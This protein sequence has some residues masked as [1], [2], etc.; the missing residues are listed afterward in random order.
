MPESPQWV[1]LAYRIPREP[2]TPRIAIWRK[3]RKLG[4]VQLLDGLVALP[5]DPRT[6]E[7][8]EWIA[9]D[10][11][12][13][14]G[15]AGIWLAQPSTKAMQRSLASQ[16]AADVDD[17]YGT[18]IAAAQ[19]ALEDREGNGVRT[20]KRLRRDLE[21][22]LERDHFPKRGY[23]RAAAALDKL[24]GALELAEEVR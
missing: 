3:L 17:E 16:M 19:A 1:L 2:S 15:E 12:A 21:R 13:A 18:L 10:V 24:D 4:A 6:R 8:L 23:A 5:L 9:E 7:H 11:V 20:A 14:G 22:I